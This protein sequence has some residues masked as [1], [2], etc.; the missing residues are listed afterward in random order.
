MAHGDRRGRSG[1][2][3]GD[4]RLAGAGWRMVTAHMQLDIQLS[5]NAELDRAWGQGKLDGPSHPY[6]R[7]GYLC[8]YRW[9]ARGGW[10]TRVSSLAGGRK[11]DSA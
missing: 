9:M 4:R 5:S 11:L 8:A 10:T 1:G 6:A 7:A 2:G 3:A